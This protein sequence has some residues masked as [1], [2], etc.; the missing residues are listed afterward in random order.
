MNSRQACRLSPKSSGVAQQQLADVDWVEAID[1]FF[2]RNRT[3]N[4][5][6]GNMSWQRCLDQD[7]VNCRITAFTGCAICRNIFRDSVNGVIRIKPIRLIPAIP[8]SVVALRQDVSLRGNASGGAVFF[9]HPDVNARRRVLSNADENQPGFNAA[10]LETRDAPGGVLMN[11]RGD[12]ATVNKIADGHQGVRAL[13]PRFAPA[14]PECV[15][16]ACPSPQARS[17]RRAFRRKS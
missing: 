16:T 13:T 6:L 5:G 8:R 12:G 9:L 2:G 17:L 14:R 1:V 4:P 11:L 15:A 10:R 7:P 3:V